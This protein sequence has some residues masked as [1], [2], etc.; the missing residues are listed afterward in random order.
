VIERIEVFDASWTGLIQLLE[1]LTLQ[2]KVLWYDLN[3][4][5]N[6]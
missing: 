1:Q 5:L 2:V 3:R 4:Q 6:D